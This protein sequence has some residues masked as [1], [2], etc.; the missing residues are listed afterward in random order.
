MSIGPF[1]YFYTGM[2][3]SWF[4]SVFRLKIQNTSLKSRNRIR[5]GIKMNRICTVTCLTRLCRYAGLTNR[6]WAPVWMLLV[7]WR[8]TGCCCHSSVWNY[9]IIYYENSHSF[10]HN[11][12]FN[13][14][15]DKIFNCTAVFLT[16]YCNGGVM[17]FC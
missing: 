7:G 15:I 10:L 8:Y 11:L 5:I 3:G 12:N 16:L 9:I 13:S 4:G 14:L 1:F 6:R 17:Q 2:C